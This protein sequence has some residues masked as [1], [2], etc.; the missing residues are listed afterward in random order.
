[1]IKQRQCH[2]L[3]RYRIIKLLW[4]ANR[5][6][7]Y[8]IPVEHHMTRIS[9]RTGVWHGDVLMDLEMPAAWDVQVFSPATPPPLSSGEI[10]DL[11][12]RPIG[13]APLTDL[14]RGKSRP[15]IIVD[16]MNRP[17]PVSAIM[18]LLLKRICAAGIPLGNITILMAT[19]THGKPGPDAFAKKVGREAL[20]CRLLVHDCFRDVEKIGVT[21]RG[22]TV[23][24]NRAIRQSDIVIGVG[25]IYPNHTAG[26]GGGSKLALGVL[27]IST[28]YRLHYCHQAVHWG[29]RNTGTGFR[30][31]LDEIARLIGM[32]TNISAIIDADRRIIRMYCGDQSKYFSE[33]VSYYAETFG[34]ANRDGADVVISNTYP[35]DLSLTFAR[36][37][38]FV[39]LTNCRSGVSRIAVAS[40]NEGVGFHNI[41]PFVNVPRMHKLKHFARVLSVLPFEEV[42]TKAFRVLKGKLSAKTPERSDPLHPVW[43]YKTG[44]H[45]VLPENIPGMRLATDW[46]QI[47][48]AVTREQ[49][50]R[51]NLKVA[52]YPCAF[53]QV[54][55]DPGLPE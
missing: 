13:Q 30:K 55:K 12:D 6:A 39:P 44:N 21:S 9:I 11:L 40:C 22:T 33:A 26:F 15:L 49:G 20:A 3:F 53:L 1:M 37:K 46:Q 24:A 36:M 41:W 50:D 28:I 43:L 27:G 10:A 23:F 5:N 42:K 45:A 4:R 8:F 52:V 18:P 47:T 19:G 51:R 2:R 25:G 31:E 7:I 35:N 32:R 38:G 14:C 16:D 48:E 34:V 54:L 29:D 17:T